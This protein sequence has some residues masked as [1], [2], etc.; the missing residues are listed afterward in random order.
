MC[1]VNQLRS[2]YSGNLSRV[3]NVVD[4]LSVIDQYQFLL[5]I[6]ILVWVMF[7]LLRDKI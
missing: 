6:C 3:G 5:H 4:Y 2:D 7:N 1:L